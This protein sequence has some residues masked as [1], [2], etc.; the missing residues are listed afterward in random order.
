MPQRLNRAG[1]VSLLAVA[2]VASLAAACG[3]RADSAPPNPPE[4]SDQQRADTETELR[5]VEDTLHQ[6]DEQR[7]AIES[8]IDSVR[9]DRARLSAALIDTTAQV[10]DAERGAAAAADRLT[11]LNATADELSHSLERRRGVIADVL[12]ALQR[13]GS[14]PPPAILVKPDDMSE[15]VRAAAVMGSLIPELKSEI[16]AA[17][18]DLDDLAKTRES[19]ARER[20]ALT[21][22]GKALAAEKMR[23]AALIEARQQ[24]LASAQDALGSQQQRAADL[25]KKAGSLK[26]LIARLDSESAARQAAALAAHESEVAQANEIEARAQAAQ[27]AETPRLKPEIAFADAKGRV[28]LPAAGAILK[29]FGS[30][31]DL[32]GVERGVSLATP[33]G[34]TVSTPVDGAV[35]FAGAYRTYGKLL[36]IDAGGG[37]Y[38]LLAGLDRINVQSGESVLAGEPVGVMGDGSTR[39]ATAAAVGAARPVL[40]IELRKDGTAID[41]GPWW[42]KTDIE[43]ARG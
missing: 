24:S 31:D 8:E 18:R 30:P 15:A 39:M 38:V 23:L 7:R 29:T 37:Y 2:F 10:Q 26:D 4:A 13:M 36:I 40:Y 6:S 3:A 41:P 17:R 12:A 25:A 9:T 42:A 32:G 28:P 22:K 20:D 19:I 35:L 27:G 43:K 16:E 1:K 11:S 21:E 14:N 5:G 34:A 33:A